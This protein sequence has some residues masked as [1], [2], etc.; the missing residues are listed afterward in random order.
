MGVCS[1]LAAGSADAMLRK[2]DVLLYRAKEA[3][4]NR[5]CHI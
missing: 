3:G 4:R 2:A 5:V 1:D